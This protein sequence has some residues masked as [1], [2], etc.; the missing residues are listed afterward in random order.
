LNTVMAGR[1]AVQPDVGIAAKRQKLERRMADEAYMRGEAIAVPPQLVSE[2]GALRAEV[3]SMEAA[4]AAGV[5][6]EVSIGQQGLSC[7]DITARC[8]AG[9][10]TALCQQAVGSFKAQLDAVIADR[11]PGCSPQVGAIS[12]A[13]NDGG[14]EE[15]VPEGILPEMAQLE[16][17]PEPE[18]AVSSARRHLDTPSEG[19]PV[20]MA[21]LEPEPEPER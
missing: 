10:H 19:A 8:E 11:W 12:L 6:M 14:W 20:R 1:H 18:S 13:A 16:P 5:Q 17:E 4:A 21:Q 15:E 3:E 9:G 2:I 7:V